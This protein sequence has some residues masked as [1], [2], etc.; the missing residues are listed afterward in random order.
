MNLKVTVHYGGKLAYEVDDVYYDSNFVGHFTVAACDEADYEELRQVLR[1]HFQISDTNTVYAENHLYLGG[2][3]FWIRVHDD[4]TLKETFE[5][6]KLVIQ[7]DYDDQLQLYIDQGDG[8]WV[9]QLKSSTKYIPPFNDAVKQMHQPVQ[10]IFI[11]MP[12]EFPDDDSDFE[13]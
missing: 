9:D 1:T 7:D 2:P 11:E 12:G 3:E 5:I 13:W 10:G 6:Q 4:A 8:T